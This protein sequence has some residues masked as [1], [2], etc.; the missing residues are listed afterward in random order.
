MKRAERRGALTARACLA[1]HSA[2][3]PSYDGLTLDVCKQYSHLL[4]E[5]DN[6]LNY[7]QSEFPTLVM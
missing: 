5:F 1:W 6:S 4:E 3:R 2:S 7:S